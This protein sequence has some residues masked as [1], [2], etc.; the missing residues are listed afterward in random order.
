M[1]DTPPPVLDPR[2]HV[3][4]PDLAD[5]ALEGQVMADRFVAGTPA[6]VNVGRLSLREA[7]DLKARQ[8]SELLFGEEVTVFEHDRGWAWLKNGTDGYVGYAR[9]AALGRADRPATHMVRALRS[10]LFPEPDLKTIPRD[11]LHLTSRV[12]VV[13]REGDW[14]R[15]AATVEAESGGWVW[16]AHLTKLGGHARDPI[17]TAR[18]FMGAPYAW[19]GRSTE[20]LDCSALVQLSLAR[21]GLACPRDSDMQEAAIGDVLEGGADAAQP[22]DLLFWPGHVAFVVGGGRILHANGHH[23][24]VAE[25]RLSEFRARTLEK[26]GDVRTV[27]RP[28]LLAGTADSPKKRRRR[29]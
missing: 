1:T 15:L 8:G 16:A 26:I 27:R 5:L 23:M 19:G 12:T 18:R 17:A 13:G 22:G 14:M 3:Y 29:R 4:R 10:Y 24:A 2:L 9:A 25:E 11:V 28:V 20:G 21:C 7:P 6:K